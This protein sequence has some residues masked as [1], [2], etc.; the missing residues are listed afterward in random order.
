MSLEDLNK[1]IANKEA[2]IAVI[3]LGYVGLPVACVFARQ[4]FDVLGVEIKSER[5]GLINAGVSPFDSQ[6]PGLPDLLSKVVH[7]RLLRA[8][9]DYEE[10]A[11]R[12][13]VLIDVE[14]PVDDAHIPQYE[15]LR[16]ALSNLSPVLK[17]EALVIVES[18]I[19]P[20]TMQRVVCPM[21]EAGSGRKVNEGF[22]LGACPERVMPGK[23]LAN[24][25]SLSRVIGAGSP[26]TAA[27]MI[28]LYREVVRADLDP[29]D[30]VTAE[31]VKTVEN[32]Y[33]DVQIAFA[34]E[35]ALICEAV[36]AD[37]WKVRELVNKTPFRSMHLPG[38]GVGGHC[39]PKDPWLLAFC[40]AETGIPLT[41]LPA[42]RQVNDSMPNHMAALVAAALSRAGR[43]IRDARILMLG[44]AYLEDSDD[45]RNSPSIGLERNLRELGA[46]V[47]IHDPF[48]AKYHG[49]LLSLSRD[50]DAAVL[51]V[52]H[53]AYRSIDLATLRSNMRLPVLIDGRH[54]LDG[55]VARSI[56]FDYSCIGTGWQSG[57]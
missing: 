7:D 54:L 46:T 17:A 50:C 42:A 44:F 36:D 21:L 5:V 45:T 1:R 35:V 57:Q 38:A 27:V 24:L 34:N 10:L 22:F 47:I 49:D 25:A 33:R 26:D 6:E 12:D 2:R 13:V 23:L 11:D 39:I 3:G 15:A 52:K 43:P 20:G 56:G 8:T 48:I 28:A 19:A 40:V 30:W 31:L 9:S 41:M 32:A 37:V 51:M 55:E 4:G 53:S 16:A 29:A 18:T 14:T